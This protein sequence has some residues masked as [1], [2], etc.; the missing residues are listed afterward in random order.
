M[1]TIKTVNN[2][3]PSSFLKATF[4]IFFFIM[5]STNSEAP[6]THSLYLLSSYSLITF[7]KDLYCRNASFFCSHS[8]NSGT[9]NTNRGRLVMR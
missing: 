7:E 5:L 3:L 1:N 9:C 4:R 2:K 8:F 6:V